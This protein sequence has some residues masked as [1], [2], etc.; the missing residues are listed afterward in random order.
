MLRRSGLLRQRA[1][2]LVFMHQTIIEYLAARYVA[3]DP[4]RTSEMWR[5]LFRKSLLLSTFARWRDPGAD[6]S[7]QRFL[8]AGAGQIG[9]IF[10]MLWYASQSTKEKV[11]R[12]SPLWLRI[13]PGIPPA[14]TKVTI[15][16]LTKEASKRCWR[17]NLLPT[18][19]R[20][21]LR[22]GPTSSLTVSRNV[23]AW[24]RA[25]A[26][27]AFGRLDEERAN[28]MLSTFLSDP[29]VTVDALWWGMDGYRLPMTD[30]Q[31]AEVLAQSFSTGQ[32]QK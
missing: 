29:T 27:A 13:V 10:Q 3:E 15:E 28:A 11:V 9:M 25:A 7:Y 6:W 30:P 22:S 4:L 14:V 20:S 12:S 23:I 24:R 32:R 16:R 19:F 8:I 2:D 31:I 18:V 17:D 26:I 21:A 5:E 1:G